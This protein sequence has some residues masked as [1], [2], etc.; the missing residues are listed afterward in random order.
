MQ[1]LLTAKANIDRILGK[2]APARDTQKKNGAAVSCPVSAISQK[3]RGR[4]KGAF[5][6]IWGFPQQAPE[7]ALWAFRPTMP[8]LPVVS[9]I[10][11]NP[12][13]LKKESLLFCKKRVK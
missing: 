1:E 13:L 12:V 10:P 9:G 7:A 6:G 5:K 11:E 4:S 2:E 8:R 3:S